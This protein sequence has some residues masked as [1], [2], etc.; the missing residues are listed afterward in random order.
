MCVCYILYCHPHWVCL[1]PYVPSFLS[2]LLTSKT[3]L[4]SAVRALR[5]PERYGRHAQARNNGN[6][7]FGP[8][9]TT[10]TAAVGLT[11]AILDTFPIIKFGGTSSGGAGVGANGGTGANR[12]SGS[13]GT[14][15]RKDL[16]NG[17]GIEMGERDSGD[18]SPQKGVGMNG[19]GAKID[20]G[21]EELG[22]LGIAVLRASDRLAESDS[23]PNSKETGGQAQVN[24]VAASTRAGG[25]RRSTL[26]LGQQSLGGSSVHDEHPST[27]P[28]SL[29]PTTPPGIPT[30]PTSTD[31]N[32]NPNPTDR[33]DAVNPSQIGHET[34]PICILDF[35][36]GDDL[37]VL[38][39]EGKHRFHQRCVDQ[40][41]L[42]MSSSCPLCREGEFR[43]AES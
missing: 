15:E 16:E 7:N 5:H 19:K 1:P 8:Q 42:E 23:E 18:A 21:E 25:S 36:F 22:E 13:T 37:R 29:N 27:T 41:L 3:N 20:E 9:G 24:G 14:G 39:C 34:C 17:E 6:P 12:T 30:S 33:T 10:R 28:A 11:R 2:P 32:P 40:W 43:F 31:P 35:E 4:R 38:P 26:V